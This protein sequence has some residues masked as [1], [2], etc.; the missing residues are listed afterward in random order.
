MARAIIKLAATFSLQTVAEGIEQAEQAAVLR[1]LECDLGQGYHFGKPLPAARI[2]ALLGPEGWSDPSHP[3][4]LVGLGTQLDL[5]VA[6]FGCGLGAA[7]GLPH[8][9]ALR[10][11]CAGTTAPGW[12]LRVDRPW[13]R[14]SGPVR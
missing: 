11:A 3:P 13:R 6:R 10:E 9:S 2:E 5:T 8:A 4:R 14:T 1:A 7:R 12:E